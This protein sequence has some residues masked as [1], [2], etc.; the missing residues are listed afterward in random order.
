MERLGSSTPVQAF[1][2]MEIDSPVLREFLGAGRASAAGVAVS[3]K[4]AMRNSGFFRASKLI[5]TAIGMLPAHLHRRK[6]DGST[7]K[8]KDHPFYRVLLKR[9]NSYQTALEF[10]TQMQLNALLDGNAYARVVWGVKGGKPAVL[11]LLPFKR[12]TIT[13]ELSD[14]G[15]LTFKYQPRGAAAQ[16]LKS[17]EVFHFRHPITTD[18]IKGVSLLDVAVETL[19]LASA[20]ERALAKM[21][22]KGVMAG[23]AIQFPNELGDGAYDRLRESMNED[24]SGAENAGDWFIL[25]EGGVANPFTT[26][27]DS[28][29]D[30]MRKRQVEEIARF[31]DVPR[32]L[33]MMDETAWGTGI[34]T[35]GI[36]FVTY[37]LLGWFVAWEQAVERSCL[38]EAE[39]DADEL[40]VKFNEGALL[41][42]S[43]KDQADFFS[44]ALGNNGAWMVP[45]EVRS[46]FELNPRDDGN[47]LPKP[48]TKAPE[49]PKEPADEQ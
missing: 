11:A 38:T 25:E 9:P 13:P 24:H 29:T 19:G 12:R 30:E 18:G 26:A 21:L 32:P 3:E 20:A 36:F 35:L 10:K 2:A 14:R 47:E 37:C 7:E 33:L 44:K 1:T 49:K 39:Q 5:A 48:A 45:N 34:E 22:A 41:R 15:D 8:A 27:K 6:A 23:G 42:G 43:L 40:Y 17:R 4:L 46:N 16:I 31:T 28:Q